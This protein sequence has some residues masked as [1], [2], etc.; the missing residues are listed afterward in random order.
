MRYD[1]W[2]CAARSNAC[3]SWA[4]SHSRPKRGASSRRGT[5]GAQRIVFGERRQPEDAD[6]G[7]VVRRRD[8]PAVRRD[9]GREALVD[10]R[11]KAEQRLR[12]ELTAV[13]LEVD[14]QDGQRLP[15]GALLDGRR[16]QE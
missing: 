5:R 15:D 14:V 12:V 2:P 7:H 3:R 13:A 4:S 16:V 8:G 9:R 6:E 10:A 11:G 1:V